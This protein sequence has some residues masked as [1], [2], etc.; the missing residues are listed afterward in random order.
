MFFKVTGK[1]NS[2]ENTK[3][4]FINFTRLADRLKPI[5]WPDE[6]FDNFFLLNQEENGLKPVAT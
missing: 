5:S 2:V 1:I 3:Y 4:D 6:G